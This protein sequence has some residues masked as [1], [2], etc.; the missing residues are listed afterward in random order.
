MRT[1]SLALG[2]VVL[3]A[4]GW[5]VRSAAREID[6]PVALPATAYVGSKSCQACHAEHYASWRRTFHRTMTQVA[7]Q[8]S[9]LGNFENATFTLDG[10]TSRFTHEGDSYFIET[11]D[12]RGQ[13]TRQRVER[14]VGS[15]RIQQYVT[16]EGDR[17]MRVPLAWNIEERRWFHLNAG[18][19]SPDGTDFNAHRSL[20]DANCIFCHN[21]KAKPG[22]DWARQK[23]DSSVA[24]LG[25]ACEAC[26]A[27]GAEHVARNAN[28][29]RRYVLEYGER[30]DL[31]TVS[32]SRLAPLQQVQVCG[33]CHGQRLPDPESRIREFLTDGDPF[34]AGEDLSRFTK[35]LRIDSQLPG[36]DLTARFWKDGTP[37]LS[38]YEYQAL[39]M[40]PDFQKGGLTCQKCHSMHSGDV[41]GMIEPAK[42]TAEACRECHAAIVADPGQHSGHPVGRSGADCYGCHLPSLVYGLLAIHPTHRISTPDP[43]RAWKYDMPDACVLCHTNKSAQWAAAALQ[44]QRSRTETTLTP[45]LEARFAVAESVRLL[46]NG[47]VISRAVAAS[48]LGAERNASADPVE[49]LWVVP[50]LL[51]AMEDSYPAV[52]HMAFRSLGQVV[53]RAKRDVS[54]P[55]LDF[56]PQASPQLRR[57]VVA[58]WRQWWRATDKRGVGRDPS[59]PLDD[60]FE[61]LPDVVR[62][63]RSTRKETVVSIGE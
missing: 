2:L 34:T 29:V 4:I 44:R 16:R 40:T 47:D 39:V 20:W 35:P 19:L 43:T 63:L 46:L 53:A 28:P 61:P 58:L 55:R 6:V 38:A 50:F 56:E 14:T 8:S 36:V 17:F 52:R 10:V 60:T 22:Y 11:L 18:F 33:H 3:L 30:P 15:R 32:P 41:R 27:P 7:G 59:V 49:R 45:D 23:F 1:V 57:E 48:T 13:F 31:S 51:L 5:A 26:H 21:V 25:I 54:A 24:E 37:R 62:T 9:V 42:R 12:G